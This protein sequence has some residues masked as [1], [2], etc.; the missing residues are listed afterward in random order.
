[1]PIHHEKPNV[2]SHKPYTPGTPTHPPDINTPQL[3]FVLP[4]DTSRN[5]PYTPKY[6]SK[7][8]LFPIHYVTFPFNPSA[9]LLSLLNETTKLIYCKHS[10]RYFF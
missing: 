9:L 6:P 7:I 5:E 3:P 10:I 1:M 8:S 4:P 2:Y